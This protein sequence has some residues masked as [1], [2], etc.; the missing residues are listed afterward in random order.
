MIKS[1]SHRI[2]P[3][4]IE[5]IIM[6]IDDVH[7][8]VVIGAE[9]NIL[10]E[11]IHAYVVLKPDHYLNEKDIVKY[12]RRN[13]PAFKVPHRIVIIDELP[14]TESGKIKKGELNP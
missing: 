9:D 13:L 2:A 8:T 5:E 4:E 1:G 14:K 6:E 10:G 3:K 11:S 7:E 12:C